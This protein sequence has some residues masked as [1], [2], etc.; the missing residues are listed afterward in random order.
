MTSVLERRIIRQLSVP[1][2]RNLDLLRS[3]IIGRVISR[4]VI[5]DCKPVNSIELQRKAVPRKARAKQSSR[6]LPNHGGARAKCVA[7][8]EVDLGPRL[9]ERSPGV[10]VRPAGIFGD[11]VFVYIS[12]GE[13]TVEVDGVTDFVL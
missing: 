6:K 1:A 10:G 8:K 9:G 11:G 7:N 4:D 2:P 13:F 3:E 12:V 5:F